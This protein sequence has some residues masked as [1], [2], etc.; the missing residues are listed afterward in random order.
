MERIKRFMQENDWQKVGIAA[1]YGY[2]A[3]N[4]LV[5]AFG[6]DSSDQIYKFFMLSGIMFLA[7]KLV[8]TKY[9]LREV[10]WCALLLGSGMVIWAVTKMATLLFLFVTIIGMKGCSYRKLIGISVW[11]RIFVAAVMVIGSFGGVYDIGY[12]TTPNA[13]YVEVPVYGF[14]FGEPNTAFLT[15]FLA[16]ALLI[17]YNYEKLNGWWFA[18]TSCVALLF[19]EFTFCR[20]G[21]I[22]FFFLWALIIYEKLVKGKKAKFILALSVPVGAL[23]SFAM[24]ILYDSGSSLMSTLDRYT[25]GRVHITGN[26]YQDQ[27]LALLPRNQELFYASYHGL[28]D[29]AYMYILL[30]CGWIFALAFFAAICVTLVRLWRRGCYRELV[31]MGAFALYGV[32]EQFVLNGFMNPF[33]LLTG[34]LL[35]PGLLRTDTDG[36]TNG[37]VSYS[38]NS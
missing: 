20:T 7:I 36:G 30:Y 38:S 34:I 13:Q 4:V 1:Y 19:Y 27:G 22:V 37:K 35:Y 9:T 32:L 5:K 6:Y 31:L 2:F 11:L 33:I 10:I 8:T 29:N 12:K 16:L 23:F 14:G 17:Y 3:V 28:I 18:G 21:I 25:S 24:M 15:I 26:Y